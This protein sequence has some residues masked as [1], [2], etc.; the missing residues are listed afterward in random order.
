MLT[1]RLA[2]FED[3]V[4]LDA[5]AGSGAMGI[6]ALSRGARRAVFCERDKAALDALSANLERLGAS[7][8][9]VV[10]GDVEKLADAG[11]LPG[12]PFSLLLLDPP[13][14][15]AP[16]QVKALAERLLA[17]GQLEEDTVACYEH[18]SGV[19]AEWPEGFEALVARAYGDTTISIARRVGAAE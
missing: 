15:M 6:E 8:A 12:G 5:F 7:D 9:T 2:T 17:T 4:V 10:R 1:S 13:F 16:A 3:R 18:A 14:R 11:R 19:G